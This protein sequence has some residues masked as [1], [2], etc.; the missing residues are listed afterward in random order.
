[1]LRLGGKYTSTNTHKYLRAGR[2]SREATPMEA[3]TEEKQRRS[4]RAGNG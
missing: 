1:M 3:N 2:D 4:V